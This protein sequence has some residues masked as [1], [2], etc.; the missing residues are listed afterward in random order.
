M[1]SNALY[2][3]SFWGEDIRHKFRAFIADT[4][5][6]PPPTLLW[7]I[8]SLSKVVSVRLFHNWLLRR[9]GLS[10]IESAIMNN[11]HLKPTD[12][13]EYIGSVKYSSKSR[14]LP[15]C[16]TMKFILILLRWA[17]ADGLNERQTIFRPFKRSRTKFSK[18]LVEKGLQIAG[19]CFETRSSHPSRVVRRMHPILTLSPWAPRRSLSS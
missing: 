1:Y 6:L 2:S 13:K 9:Y 7:S 10:K 18:I 15:A 19:I 12:S 16:P 17:R 3:S 4:N 8:I 5:K 11:Y 14:R